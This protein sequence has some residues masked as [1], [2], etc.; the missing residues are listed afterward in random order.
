[1]WELRARNA[2]RLAGSLPELEAAL[3]DIAAVVANVRPMHPRF[4]KAF[5]LLA[6]LDAARKE[7]RD[8]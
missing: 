6:R 1:M 8:G 3:K 5:A 2:E 4:A 7:G